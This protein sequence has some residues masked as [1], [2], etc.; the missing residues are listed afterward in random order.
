MASSQ[1][2]S[3]S[4]LVAVGANNVW[5]IVE[6]GQEGIGAA[7]CWRELDKIEGILDDRNAVH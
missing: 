6:A 4:A 5:S 7:A 1:R 3:I 2:A